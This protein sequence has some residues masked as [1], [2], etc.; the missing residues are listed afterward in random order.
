MRSAMNKDFLREIRNTRSRF[1]SILILV[2]LS[3]AFLSGLRATAPDMKRTGDDYADSLHLADIQVLSNLGLTDGDL[4]AL[5]ACEEVESGEAVYV[6]DAYAAS[7]DADLVAKVYS[8]TDCDISN[9]ALREGRM[10]Q[11]TDECV[12][13]EMLLDQLD[14]E[15]GDS[16]TLTPSEQMEDA[17][18]HERFKV[19]GTIR[20]PVYF[21][22]ERGTSTLGAGTVKA[23]LYLPKDAFSL[24]YYTAINL[25]VKGAAELTAFYEEYD[26]SVDAVID[27]LEPLGDE[28]AALRHDELVDE[29]TEKLDDAQ[30]KL[31]DAK[32]EADEEL[33]KAER[34]L[35]DARKELDDGWQ[36]YRDG[37]QE[38][39]DAKIEVADAY[40]ELQDGEQEY[41]DGVEEL[42]DG[43]EK[44]EDGKKK[45][46]DG[47]A[48]Y[49]DGLAELESARRKLEDGEAEYQEGKDAFDAFAENYLLH[50]SGCASADELGRALVK[51]GSS[52][53]VHTR[54]D[55]A[56]D[57]LRA[58]ITQ[59]EASEEDIPQD[60]N[61]VKTSYQQLVSAR[62]ELD[63]G[64]EQYYDGRKELRSAEQELEDAETELADALIE[65]RDGEQ[66]LR[67]ARRELD[68]GWREYYDG[69]DEIADAETELADALVELRDGEQEYRDGYQ[70]YL[71]AKSE[72][73]EKIAD[74]EREIADARRKVA[75][76]EHGEWYVMSRS[77]NPGYTGFGQDADRMGNLASVFPVIFFLVAALVCLTTM[78]R[79]VE[80]Q[81]I[82]IG[83]LK[84]LGY[85]R[86]AISAK[87]IGYGLLP[88]VIGGV[89]GL[90]IGYTVFPKMI[91]TAYQIMYQVPDIE[92]RAYPDI[93]AFS[94]LAAVV[95]TTVST[96]WACLSTLREVPA[97][98]MRPRT[99]KAGKRVFLEYIRPLW[100]RL[101]FIHKVTARNLFR[102]QKRFW[103]TVIGI[104]GCTALIIAGFGLRSSILYTMSRQYSELFHYT[105]Q[106]VLSDSVL[107]EEREAIE[108]FL[109][110]DARVTDLAR[111]DISSATAASDDYSVTAYVEVLQ[112]GDL[113]RFMELYDCK[114]GETI[115][116]DDGGVYIDQKLS[117]LLGVTVGDTFLVDGDARANVTVAGIFEHYTGH[118]IYMTPGYYERTFGTPAETGAY[119]LT[120][121][122]D[123]EELCS[124]LFEELLSLNGVAATTRMRDTQDTYQ[125]S[126][127][128]IDFVVVIVILAA[129]ALA[130]VVLYN[131][132]NINITERL[133][134]LATIKLL[135]FYDGEVSAYVYR[136]NIVLTVI[137][138]AVGILMGHYLH[139]WLVLSTEIDLMMF[140]RETDPKS[141][142]YAAVLTAL[143]SF[144]VNLI[145]HFKMKKIDMVESL[146]SAE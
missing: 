49:Q 46:E 115:T 50:S 95:C 131:L 88:S 36:E 62:A 81:R 60:A 43:A 137:G 29:A 68:D 122:S 142:L 25:R 130:V 140:G 30:Q 57:A 1:L 123:D 146:K 26:D 124:A 61:A 34:E 13:E 145:A 5:L 35:A 135:G 72:A 19:V 134:E 3:V 117:E 38:L 37:V 54:V 77:Y 75:E 114:T 63:D 93:S 96:L 80:E 70:E 102:Y 7:D 24:D 106:V 40:I 9:V 90:L 143:F 20:S 12:V 78:T 136:E 16:I 104:G 82:Q 87:Y 101:K 22:V 21:S 86:L 94:V 42:R 126:M 84:A 138:I 120:L 8:L 65:L 51:E 15:L 58:Q 64:W 39:A 71:D 31:D 27:A 74:A 14:I 109:T 92:L 48:E 79:M 69:L 110:T 10:P 132:S 83:S 33:G 111:C 121:E 52:G 119:L 133:R 18:R 118:F 2:A 85:S 129:A 4:A 105:A 107:S 28:R 113:P 144:L 66:E 41:A 116:L 53:E 59:L 97:S 45:Y 47:L 108:E 91:F 127:E 44:Y 139:T 76:I 56:L 125:H 55:A 6:I 112:P 11:R 17:L 98:L 99:P 141:Y 100:K 103:M 23:Y 67:D 73:E 89:L 128:R 32:A